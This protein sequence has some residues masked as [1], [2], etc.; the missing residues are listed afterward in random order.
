MTV[1]HQFFDLEMVKHRFTE[2]SENEAGNLGH[3]I[4][5]RFSDLFIT[6]SLKDVMFIKMERCD[7]KTLQDYIDAK[8][9]NL[10]TGFK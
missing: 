2:I 3:N 8:N 10:F 9:G 4:N 5:R 1:V 6:H 7:T